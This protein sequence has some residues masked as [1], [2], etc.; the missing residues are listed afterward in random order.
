MKRK[1]ITEI[2]TAL[3][4]YRFRVAMYTCCSIPLG[5][6]HTLRAAGGWAVGANILLHLIQSRQLHTVLAG[7]QAPSCEWEHVNPG[8]RRVKRQ[9][10]GTRAFSWSH[11]DNPLT[12]GLPSPPPDP[13]HQM[14][15]GLSLPG[16][17]WQQQ[18][19]WC[20]NDAKLVG[21][22]HGAVSCRV[23]LF[24]LCSWGTWHLL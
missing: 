11:E 13:T 1:I 3:M 5:S 8:S 16:Q 7:H 21:G 24:S 22:G 14:L 2:N 19:C 23:M 18:F 20:C 6:K 4:R 12:R 15:L 17:I 10:R 9:S